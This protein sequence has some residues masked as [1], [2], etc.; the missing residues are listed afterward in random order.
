MRIAI[1]TD[2]SFRLG[3]GHVMRCLTLAEHAKARGAEVHFV[4]SAHEGSNAEAITE[5]G[6]RL[7]LIE[8]GPANWERDAAE[9]RKAIGPDP[10]DWLVVDH[11]ELDRRWE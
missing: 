1:R 7:E 3:T 8:G 4:V 2:S 6:H 9:T 5:R 10:V 11:Y